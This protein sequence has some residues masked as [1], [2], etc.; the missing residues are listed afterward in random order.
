MA[1]RR[2]TIINELAG[3]IGVLWRADNP[4]KARILSNHESK[5]I[6]EDP[7]LTLKG[8]ESYFDWCDNSPL[9]ESRIELYRGNWQQGE[10]PHM[11]AYTK[12]GCCAFIGVSISQW[13]SWRDGRVMRD[14]ESMAGYTKIDF[15]DVS[16]AMRAL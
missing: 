12:A 14:G 9:M 15:G 2:Q 4:L 11:R 13:D 8:I 7:K 6:F 1:E 16:V 3:H 5:I 10:I